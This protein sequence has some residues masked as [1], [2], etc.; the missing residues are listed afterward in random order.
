MRK[1]S[2]SQLFKPKPKQWALR[3]DPVLWD[4]MAK[5]LRSE[6][7]PSSAVELQAIIRDIFRNITGSPLRVPRDNDPECLHVSGLDEGGMSGGMVSLIFWSEQGL[8][9]LE[10]RF[11][12][13]K[14]QKLVG[15][16]KLEETPM[17]PDELINKFVSFF[18]GQELE[19][20]GFDHL[21]ESYKW[22]MPK[23]ANTFLGLQPT[24]GDYNA[25]VALKER[26][27]EMWIQGPEERLAIAKWVISDWGGVRRNLEETLQSYVGMAEQVEPKTPIKGV[28]SYSKLLSVAH[29]EKFAIYD[30]R[31]AVALNAAQ[32]LMGGAGVMFPYLPGRN[33]ITGDVINNRGFSQRIE[34]SGPELLRHGWTVLPPR[35]G[36]QSYMQL[37]TRVRDKLPQNLR[38]HDLEMTLF[39]QA[40]GLATSAM[41]TMGKQG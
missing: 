17:L 12:S 35:H 25:T 14:E 2:L 15:S 31:V 33:K 3:G 38:L 32:F 39:S 11:R 16:S 36:Y 5:E 22:S 20:F 28:A 30:A 27:H 8:P 18:C 6:P 26:L 7:L 41:G 1:K 13:L 19:G 21:T 34:F 23:T 29:P 10:N 40:E 9:E 24:S 4:R 37:L